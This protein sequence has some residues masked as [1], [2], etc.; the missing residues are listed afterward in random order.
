MQLLSSFYQ[1]SRSLLRTFT[2][3]LKKSE[4]EEVPFICDV[5]RLLGQR[6][7]V[8]RP[9]EEKDEEEPKKKR[10]RYEPITHR[11]NK[12]ASVWDNNENEYDESIECEDRVNELKMKEILIRRILTNS[13]NTLLFLRSTILLV[14]QIHSFHNQLLSLRR[15]EI[16]DTIRLSDSSLLIF[17]FILDNYQLSISLTDLQSTYSR[18]TEF[19]SSSN[20]IRSSSFSLQS[21]LPSSSLILSCLSISSWSFIW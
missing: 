14:I 13:E 21:S 9:K 16:S 12:N 15:S 2:K 1:R 8:R 10:Q 5:S 7:S 4:G 19:K 17:F 6:A 20:L 18:S 11:V 3:T